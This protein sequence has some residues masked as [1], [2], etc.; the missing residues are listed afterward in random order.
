MIAPLARRGAGTSRREHRQRGLDG[1]LRVLGQI[2]VYAMSKAAVDPHDPRDGTG[3]GQVRHQRQCTVPGYIDTEI[4]HHHWQTEGRPETG[5]LLAAQAR[6]RPQD[7]DVALMMC[8]PMKR[9]HQRRR[10]VGGRRLRRLS[11]ATLS[12]CA[13]RSRACGAHRTCVRLRSSARPRHARDGNRPC[14]E[15]EKQAW[16]AR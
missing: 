8:A 10:L 11:M 12:C 7:L 5:H 3:V 16:R 13:C 1:G 15:A 9:L 4:N 6:R 14:S 2:G